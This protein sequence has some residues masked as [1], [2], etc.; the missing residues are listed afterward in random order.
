M[1]NDRKQKIV[2]KK[3]FLITMMLIFISSS[4]P[5]AWASSKYALLIG[6]SDYRLSGLMSL[7]GSGNDVQL[8]KHVLLDKFQLEEENIT[9]LRDKNATHTG[10]EKAF[11]RLA[12]K[13]KSGDFVYIHYSGHGSRVPDRDGDEYPGE[14][15]QTWVPYGARSTMMKGKDRFD[16]P[17][18]EIYL[19]LIPI[20]E[21]TEHVVFVSDSCYSATVTRGDLLIPRT[22][23]PD[24]HG[25]SFLSIPGKSLEEK[26][27]FSSSLSLLSLT[28]PLEGVNAVHFLTKISGDKGFHGGIR[29]GA[30]QDSGIACEGVFNG[31]TYGLF[32]WYWAHAL[33]QAQPGDTWGDVFKRTSKKVTRHFEGQ[34]PQF[35]GNRDK[36]LF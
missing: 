34:H 12:E 32:S 6:I 36:P 26:Q 8:I 18:D 19:W 22:V 30:V 14:V 13:I 7:E 24:R 3:N 29:I 11:S 4:A 17:D 16:I 25:F 27:L 33:L 1:V 28:I 9:I 20:F 21:K 2:G 23:P 31:K 10:I 5:G 15:D 35:H